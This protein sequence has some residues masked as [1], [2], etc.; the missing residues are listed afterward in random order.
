MSV[1]IQDISARE[2][3]VSTGFEI[4]ILV[5]IIGENYCAK[6]QIRQLNQVLKSLFIFISRLNPLEIQLMDKFPMIIQNA[7]FF[8]VHQR[9]NCHC[10]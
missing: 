2:L 8:V 6:I 7:R 4:T 5:L 9:F 10:V 1:R 3:P